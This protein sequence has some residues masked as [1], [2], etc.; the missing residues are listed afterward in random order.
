[1]ENFYLFFDKIV[2]LYDCGIV[3]VSNLNHTI[4][5]STFTNKKQNDRSNR[6]VKN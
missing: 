3:F 5:F 4:I 6:N 1:M 2:G